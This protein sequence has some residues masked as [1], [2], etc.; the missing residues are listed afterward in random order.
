MRLRELCLAAAIVMLIGLPA[1]AGS[2]TV[3]PQELEQVYRTYQQAK[4]AGFTPEALGRLYD[5]P[6]A[7]AAVK[8][9]VDM[10]QSN[11]R[12]SISADDSTT[13]ARTRQSMNMTILRRLAKI[14]GGAV[15][16]TNFGKEDGIRS[17]LDQTMY[18]VKGK[19]SYTA[20]ELTE[21]YGDLFEAEYHRPMSRMDM[22]MFNGDAYIPDWKRNDQSLDQF[23]ADYEMRQPMLDAVPEAYAEPG[24]FRAQ[25]ERMAHEK[26]RVLIVRYDGVDDNGDDIFVED[27]GSAA[28]MATRYK[29]MTVDIPYRN[30]VSATWGH[31]KKF[32]GT[33]DF[34]D[35]M[36]Y[37]NRVMGD[38]INTCS[39]NWQSIYLNDLQEARRKGGPEF[40]DYIRQMVADAY[41]DVSRDTQ[42]SYAKVIS[43]SAN[44]ELD[45]MEGKTQSQ[46]AYLVGEIHGIKR[47][48]EARGEIIDDDEALHRA[49]QSLHTHQDA[50]M[51][52]SLIATARHKIQFDLAPDGE[53]LGN[54]LDKYGPEQLR[55][56]EYDSF[57]QLQRIFEAVDD[58][59]AIRHII[60]EAP[61]HLRP[62]LEQ[63]NE[64]AKI[65]RRQQEDELKLRDSDE[66]QAKQTGP[67][68]ADPVARA[69][70]EMEQKRDAVAAYVAQLKQQYDDFS[71]DLYAGKYSDEQ[72]SQR[73][74]SRVLDALGFEERA[75]FDDM[76]EKFERQFSGSKLLSNLVD[77]GNVDAVLNVLKVYQ[78]TGDW[79]QVAQTAV[80][81]VVSNI[82]YVAKLAR[83]KQIF[84]DGDY[85]GLAWMCIAWQM[86]AAGQ[87][88]MVFDIAKGTVEVFYYHLMQPLA[89]DRFSQVYRGYIDAQPAG[90][91]P[92]QPGW[93]QR[94]NAIGRS[95]LHWVPGDTFVEKRSN[96][97]E[98]FDGKLEAKLRRNGY[99]P[100]T[101][102]YWVTHEQ[103]LPFFMRR[104]VEDYFE[105]RGEWSDN[106]IPGLRMYREDELK[107]KLIA[108]LV[109]DFTEGE[110]IFRH[111]DIA[112][113]EMLE[114]M[115]QVEKIKQEN[116][117]LERRL[118][119]AQAFI[120]EKAV[121]R[122]IQIPPDEPPA[123]PVAA[124][125]KVEAFPSTV[126][127]G[128]P[129]SI[130]VTVQTPLDEEGK[131]HKVE[132]APAKATSLVQGARDITAEQLDE[133]VDD[134][135]LL[136]SLT[137]GQETI[138]GTTY[139]E[140]VDYRVT[141]SSAAGQLLDEQ[142]VSIDVVAVQ[143]SLEDETLALMMLVKRDLGP[144]E[145][146]APGSLMSNARR[147]R[148]EWDEPSAENLIPYWSRERGD[149]PQ[150]KL[151][152]LIR[153]P[154]GPTDGAH[155]V[156]GRL[157][158][159][160]PPFDKPFEQRLSGGQK[161]TAPAASMNPYAP[162]GPRGTAF[163]FPV[164]LEQGF[165][166]AFTLEGELL[167]FTEPGARNSIKDYEPAQTYPFSISFDVHVPARHVTKTT[168]KHAEGYLE[169]SVDIE[170]CQPGKR[171]AQVVAGSRTAYVMVYGGGGR[172]SIRS[173]FYCP[174]KPAS[175]AVSFTDFGQRVQLNVPLTYVYE[176]E[177]R[178]VDEDR[179]RS[180]REGIDER[181]AKSGEDKTFERVAGEYGRLAHL[182][183]GHSGDM[184]D[185]D[186]WQ[187]AANSEIEYWQRAIQAMQNPDWPGFDY[188]HGTR[189]PETGAAQRAKTQIGIHYKFVTRAADHAYVAAKH[190]LPALA[191][192]WLAAAEPS[193]DLIADHEKLGSE[194]LD[195]MYGTYRRL[196]EY[197]VQ[198]T[199]NLE[200]AR[201]F[202]HRANEYAVRRRP[203]F[204]P[205][206]F[207]WEVEIE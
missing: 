184:L 99:D 206:D 18:A 35:R 200:A 40:D 153:W 108:Q 166:G 107:E 119:A 199:G 193:V 21:K 181:I 194:T 29:D 167:F 48:A 170:S 88:K 147:F 138:K 9:L 178:A 47:Q 177:I 172:A 111:A 201:T 13:M 135:D 45:K 7:I 10:G 197:T 1:L 186:R 171:L 95:I 76:R 62:V 146:A 165:G 93:K 190:N 20:T 39:E 58:D 205:G 188:Y 2:K 131:E 34:V 64:S 94:Q 87:V 23:K 109:R 183:C 133:A 15:E 132:V 149:P 148:Y 6:N 130:T 207:P 182:F 180:V 112:R 90:W 78:R 22:E 156:R 114:Q 159:G 42:A 168:A 11:P 83:L 75:V 158:G 143:R 123:Q 5:Q 189:H 144:V 52:R 79:Q 19:R 155:W 30:A 98:Y 142:T 129:A 16:V 69:K 73:V 43:L 173:K 134:A 80:W 89:D 101:N 113:E 162:S 96:M 41:P 14:T 36:K 174:E 74:R 110:M 192:Q 105:G 91:S 145:G 33:E 115:E 54:M 124:K 82:P 195:Q 141:V 57:H 104:Y 25:V 128:Q 196:A 8:K 70:S 203:D 55:K 63:M 31:M 72:I 32:R 84:N 85:E 60:A 127:S 59:A 121:E 53:R 61:E 191:E 92:F 100:T 24:A 187:A 97:Y 28:E 118:A 17:D 71:E 122:S 179:V 152:L 77:L 150:P 117:E 46:A 161:F 49:R 154:D 140:R 37:F 151:S 163:A 137:G 102:E 136:A 103:V 68:E 50:I 204:T 176:R 44:I 26:G 126:V 3:S 139:A 27:T 106:V 157:H 125:V 66:A 202:W 51:R 175:L 169:A 65:V 86:P 120:A 81:E 160:I 56:L 4:E 185:L 12:M 198:W 38:G 67:Q 164:P 116:I